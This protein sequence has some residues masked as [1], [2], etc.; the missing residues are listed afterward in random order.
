MRN[1]TEGDFPA[2]GSPRQ[3][4]EFAAEYA[5]LAPTGSTSRPWDF[6][7]GETQLELMA[8]DAAAPEAMDPDGR[9]LIIGC[10]SALLCL[11]LALRHF[12]CL[13]RVALFPD[14]DKPAL[15]ARVHFG[16]CRERDAREKVLFEAMSKCRADVSPLGGIPVSETMLGALG[17]AAA[18]E[19]GWLDFAHSETSRQLV[20][21][22]KQ[23]G[24][25]LRMNLERSAA[26]S[27]DFV[28]EGQRRGVRRYFA[29]GGRRMDS[30]NETMEP[31]RPISDPAPALAV[32]KTKTD[33]KHGWLA[34]GQTMART[35]LQAQALGLSWGFFNPMCR[36]EAREALRMGVGRKGYAQ[37]ILRF[38]S[39]AADGMAQP[40]SVV[41]A[42]TAFQ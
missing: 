28:A 41:Q 8:R 29:F 27:T 17:Q 6:R 30:G 16:F 32:V 3:K 4:L 15:V 42:M 21:E 1:V 9:E 26:D 14:L 35:I 37:L 11:K 36:R 18:G 12:G 10:G 19:R 13:G 7:L 34:A 23:A 38:G 24:D 31:V 40:A 25:Q 33:D 2:D 39:L 22:I 5:T 20:M